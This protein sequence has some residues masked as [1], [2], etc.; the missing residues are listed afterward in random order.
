MPTAAT[1]VSR[2]RICC[3]PSDLLSMRGIRMAEGTLCSEC[4]AMKE[5][6]RTVLDSK[7]ARRLFRP[8]LLEEMRR[9]AGLVK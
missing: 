6:L 4:A 3:E 2:C 9:R 8:A 5:A 1:D 7:H